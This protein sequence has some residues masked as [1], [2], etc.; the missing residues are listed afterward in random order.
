MHLLVFHFKKEDDSYKTIEI[1]NLPEILLDVFGKDTITKFEHD[2]C[3]V[4][5]SYLYNA[6][7]CNKFDLL[8]KTREAIVEVLHHHCGMGTYQFQSRD[9]DEVFCKIEHND[10][11][12]LQEAENTQYL[13]QMKSELEQNEMVQKYMPYLPY[14]ASKS[15]LYQTYNGSIMKDIDRIRLIEQIIRAHI[16]VEALVKHGILIDFYPVH[17]IAEVRKLKSEIL[18]ASL[19][20]VPTEGLRN[21]L[22][23]K[24][25][26]YFLWLEFY[27]S[28]LQFLGVIGVS[29]LFL[30][31]FSRDS[32]GH[33]PIH[34]WLDL[35]FGIIVCV[36]CG[37]FQIKWERKSNILARQF[38]TKGY[39]HK[40]IER[41]QFVGQI[42][43]NPITNEYEKK[44]ETKIRV[45]RQIATY[46]TT[47]FMIGLVIVLTFSLFLY[48]AILIHGGERGWGPMI[49]AIF[50]SLQIYIMNLVYDALAIKLNDWENHKTQTEYENGL[51][52]KKVG[53]QFVNYFISLF[54]IAFVKEY[55][56]GCDHN[57]C[58]GELNYSLWVMFGL[59]MVFNVIEIGVPIISAKSKWAAE[60][61]K[62]QAMFKE[63]KATRLETSEPERQAKLETLIILNEYLEVVMNFGYIIFF[64]VAFP[65]GP[66]IYWVFNILEIKGDAYKFFNLF[67]RPFPRQAESIGVW[68]DIISFLS[69]VGVIT[70]TGLMIF[71]ANIFH[72]P[73]ERRWPV[74]IVIEHVLIFL[75]VMILSYYPK[76]YGF[77][78]DIE[79]KH[80]I[81]KNQYF[82]NSF[83]NTGTKKAYVSRFTVDQQVNFRDN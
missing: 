14:V 1:P 73:I 47:F 70:N 59:N 39:K 5:L 75:M 82:Y 69:I 25:C 15:H 68:S 46:L 50:N 28:Q 11:V 63:G 57:N 60:E 8:S 35:A 20:P 16:K 37:M 24:L 76:S 45:K 21:Y 36:W 54:Y 74:F 31:I 65:L 66:L 7:S 32:T 51:I 9:N 6:K 49:I 19:S 77:V 58:M 42:V 80:E 64:C 67:K 43:K 30:S 23:E 22:G 13:F 83:S 41:E 26:L 10:E 52:I 71:T 33:S 18:R 40:E 27:T 34:Q 61:K 53:Y 29:V 56:D 2:E 38:G 78:K 55:W 4:S 48:R 72:L 17:D 44:F 3:L 12:L 79:K 81:L 62:V